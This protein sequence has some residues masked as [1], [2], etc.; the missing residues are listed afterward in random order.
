MSKSDGTGII[1]QDIW[2]EPYREKLKWRHGHFLGKLSECERIFGSL[3]EAARG[4]E[5][6]GFNRGESE[7]KPGVWYREWAPDALSLALI[8]E[9]N[10]WERFAHPM[11]KDKNGVWS[12]FVADEA[13]QSLAGGSKVKV[14]VVTKKRQIDRIPAYIREVEQDPQT[15]GFCGV[16]RPTE[17]FKWQYESPKT[18][19]NLRIYEGHVGMA[20][21]KEDVG[22]FTEFSENVLP[23]IKAQGYNAVELMAVAQHPYYGSF[24][25]QV[26]SF[27]AVSHFMGRPEDLKQLI[28]QAHGMGL[29]VIMDLVH[30]HTV[31]NFLEGI[32]EFDG[33]DYQYFHKGARGNHE[34]WDTKLFNYGKPEVLGFLLSNVGYWQNEFGF[35]GFR[36]DGVTSMLYRDH[37]LGKSFDHYDLYFDNNVDEDALVYMKLVNKLVHENKEDAVTIAEE[38]SGLPGLS[39]PIEAGGVGY[40]YRLA[41]GIP[42]YWI[43]ILKHKQDEE[44]SMSEIFETLVN[45]RRSEK[46]VAYAESHDQALVGDKTIAF[47][48]MDKHMYTDM[49]VF[50]ENAVV[51]R[52]IALHNMIRLVTFS[53]GGEAWLNFM[54]NEFGHPEWIDFPREGNNYSF[55]YARRQWSLVDNSDLRYKHMNAFDRAM[56]GLDEEKRLLSDGLIEHLW[57]HEEDK[58]LV[59]RRG[60][61]VFVFNFHPSNSYE[62][63]RV[64]VPDMSDY[65]VVLSTDEAEFGGFE[66][67]TVGQKYPVQKFKHAGREQS[68]QIYLPSRTAQVLGPV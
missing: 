1:D 11:K 16:Y 8:G 57:H 51:S 52:G 5:Y 48:L 45:R 14:F 62:G 4:Y 26:S 66:R 41:M 17:E 32:N 29:V 24:G 22:S 3:Q 40:D 28:D 43:K 64:G 21:E 18:P 37:G 9:F 49:S 36:L 30:S 61:L 34:A 10:G 63:F 13:K 56:N 42:D 39:M 31:K 33:T 46:H 60:E 27:F 68:V 50:S 58:V 6:F 55:Y 2:L 20:Q 35:D 12:V 44:W 59:Y 38:V 19:E 53:L 47:W 23:R 65:E 15:L 67:V 54:G 7:G 25:Y